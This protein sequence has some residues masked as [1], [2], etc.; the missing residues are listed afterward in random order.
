MS[1][2]HS[3][4][5]SRPQ[6]S[7]TNNIDP[8]SFD[9]AIKRRRKRIR[10]LERKIKNS[11]HEIGLE[12]ETID[13]FPKLKDMGID[14]PSLKINFAVLNENNE[15]SKRK[16]SF[17]TIKKEKYKAA[18]LRKFRK[19]QETLKFQM[20]SVKTIYDWQRKTIAFCDLKRTVNDMNSYRL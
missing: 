15:F 17:N 20:Q 6:T 13:H 2:S 7:E 12:Y 11:D 8:L 1:T 14:F 5:S 16:K 4:T 3:R 10:A 9:A 19:E 18:V